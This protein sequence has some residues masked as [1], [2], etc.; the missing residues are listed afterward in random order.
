MLQTR[1]PVKL[2]HLQRAPDLNWD[3][4]FKMGPVRCNSS[5]SE[6]VESPAL[7]M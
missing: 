6:G 4:Q 1:T 2:P 5:S 3:L 7:A